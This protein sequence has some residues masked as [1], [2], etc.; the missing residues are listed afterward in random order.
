LGDYVLG[1]AIEGRPELRLS[2]W[3][4]TN[5][6]AVTPEYFRAMG[7]RLIRGRVFTARDDA[8]APHVAVI[9]ETLA[10][11]FFP[12]EDPIGKRI[13]I[14]IGPPNSPD[15]WRE[16]VGIVADIKQYGV[17]KETTSQSYE[18]FAPSPF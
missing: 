10:R 14:T 5:Y 4:S 7:I 1:V 13:H 8:R 18:P 17:D 9:N 16:I 12:N 2:E 6:Y 11:Q 15:I 3:P